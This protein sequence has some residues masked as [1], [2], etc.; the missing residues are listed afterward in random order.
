MCVLPIATGAAQ[1]TLTQAAVAAHWGAGAQH[2]GLVQGLLSG[3]ITAFGCFIGGW[4][5]NRMNPRNA[6]SFFGL[7]L[8][9][10]AL[11]MAF[12][13]S[14]ITMY[15]VWN[16]IYAL[17]VGL[18]YAAFTAMA[19]IAIGQRAAATGYNV[20][21]SLSNFP[22]WWLGLVLGWIADHQGPRS[23]LIAEAVLGTIGVLVFTFADRKL[24]KENKIRLTAV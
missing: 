17:G 12:S 10:I 15:V 5:C 9:V 24:W 21:A 4:I 18:S 11:G 7:A 8:A 1:G 2:V 16:M 23:M 3:L 14:T 20:F 22:L 13:P 6:Y 19:L